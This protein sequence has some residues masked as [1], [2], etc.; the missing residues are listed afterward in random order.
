MN[1]F[2]FLSISC[3][4]VF[5]LSSPSLLDPNALKNASDCFLRSYVVERALAVNPYLTAAQV[6]AMIDALSGDP[7]MGSGC[8]VSAPPAEVVGTAADTTKTVTEGGAVFFA[9]AARGDDANNGSLVAPFLTVGRAVA[10]VRSAGGGGVINLRGGGTFFVREA[11]N[12]DAADAGLTIQ[13]YAADEDIAWLSGSVPLTG[14]NWTAVNISSGANIYRADVSHVEGLTKNVTSLRLNGARL[15]RARFPNSNPETDLP[16]GPH[17]SRVTASSWPQT[18]NESGSHW[19]APPS[20]ARNDSQ[21]KNYQVYIGGTVCSLYTPPISF[22]CGGATVPGGAHIPQAQ[23]PHQP[24]ADAAG[25]VITALHG[26]AWC[27]FQY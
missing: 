20:Y 16:F 21:Y 6:S 2:V 27:S 4:C 14:L 22:Y 7:L 10:A 26:G 5:S 25:A 8:I 12:L 3:L 13:T 23:L 11:L 19:V 9:D 15:I 1:I 17:G 24:Y 18:G